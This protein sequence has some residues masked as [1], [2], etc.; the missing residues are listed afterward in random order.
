MNTGKSPGLDGLTAEFYQLCWPLIKN[1][2]MEV[3][4][5]SDEI[6]SLPNSMNMALIR[7]IFKNRGER[8]DL[9][10]WRPISL[11]NVDYKI[12]AKVIT[13]RFKRIMPLI[14]ETDQSCGVKNRNIYDNLV[15]VRDAIYYVNNENKQAAILCIDQ[16]KAFDRIE[17]KYMLGMM[18][19]MG[20]PKKT[21][22]LG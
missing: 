3:I 5:E 18:V 21:Y 19:K 14:I 1:D 22:Q 2:F 15:V 13:N 8:C 9:K 7:L 12:I 4:N 10:N 17:W 16:E 11:L 6:A 20:I